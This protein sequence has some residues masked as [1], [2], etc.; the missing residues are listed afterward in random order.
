MPYSPRALLLLSGL[1]ALTCSPPPAQAQQA[2]AKQ[3]AQD[4]NCKPGKVEVVKQVNG[5]L[6]ETLYKILC[7][8]QKSADGKEVFIL[9]Q[10]KERTCLAAR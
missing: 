3:A 1:I 9:I 8:G 10:C 4:A 5:R 6:P 2:E 7:T